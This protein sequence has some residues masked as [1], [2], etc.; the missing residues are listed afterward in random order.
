MDKPLGKSFGSFISAMKD[1]R[2]IWPM[3]VYAMLRYADIPICSSQSQP[4]Q[5]SNPHSPITNPV[6]A[7]ATI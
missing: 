4:F 3:K 1:G 5:Y 2:V 6:P 7:G